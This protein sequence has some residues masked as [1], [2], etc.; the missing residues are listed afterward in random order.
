MKILLLNKFYYLSGGAERYLFEWERLLRDRGHEVMVFSMQHPRNRPCAQERFFVEQVRFD[1]RL[2]P[3]SKA[4][5]ALHAVWCS[6]A[7]TRLRALLEAEGR[8]DIA[9]LQSYMFQLTPSIL[10]PLV[11]REVPLV[12]TCHEYSPVCVNQ[13]LFSQHTNRICESCLERGPAAILSARCLK[14]SFA[15]GL[16][17]YLAGVADRRW[18]QSRRCISR[19]F[20][21]SS[22][23]RE[24]L[25]QGGLPAAHVRAVPHFIAA[26]SLAPSDEAGEYMLFLGRLVPQ[27]GIATFL[28]AAEEC[29]NIPCRI[30][31]GGPLEDEVRARIT[32]RGLRHVELLGHLEDEALHEVLR[33]ARAVVVPSEWYEPFGL[34]ILEAMAMARPV[35]AARIAGPAE[36]V[37]H[38]R[39]GLLFAPGSAAALSDAM[40]RLWRDPPLAQ[41]LGRTA[42]QRALDNFSPARHYD[43][44]MSHFQ[45]VCA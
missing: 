25:V 27:K 1:A 40:K 42:R 12:Q 18:A 28:Q 44:M 37:E 9:H 23:M 26:E 43:T 30:A 33:H 6:Q 14:G 21:P 8:P 2:S 17:G 4:K 15:A 35:I 13:R 39:T 24:K 31:G 32:A 16:A 34:V 22:F 5:A 19:Y 29:P 11:E 7:R 3:W 36:I 38:E 20:T 10:R 41:T 45:E